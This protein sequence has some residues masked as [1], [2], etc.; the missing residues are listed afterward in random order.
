MAKVLV[1]DDDDMICRFLCTMGERLGHEVVYA[2]TCSEGLKESLSKPFDIVFLDVRLP[3]GDGLDILPQIRET[4]SRPEVII[5]SGIGDPDGAELAIRNGAWDY[6]QKPASRDAVKLPLL[7]A[8]EL[9]THK[10]AQKLTDGQDRGVKALKR[11][12]IIGDSPKM[13]ICMDQ[14]AQAASSRANVVITGETGTGKELF[15]LAVHE[16]STRSSKPFVV[17]DCAALTDS[18]VESTLFGYEKGA[19]TGAEKAQDGMIKQAHGGTLML[20]EI[21]ELPLSVQKSFLRVL[22]EHRFRPVGGRVEVPSDFRLVAATNRN[23][24]QMVEEGRFRKDLFFRIRAQTIDLPP[25]RERLEDIRELAIYHVTKH[26][27]RYERGSKGFSP[28]F[29]DGLIKYD[30]PGN[31]RELVHA[32]ESCLIAAGAEPILF[33]DHLPVHIRVHLARK[34][35]TH[36]P[37]NAER[38]RTDADPDTDLP[39]LQEVRDS[40]L[41]DVERHYLKRLL[42]RTGADIKEACRI[43]GLSRSQLYCL[44]KKHGITRTN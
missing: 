30:W 33:P 34:S 40:A 35:V 20:D 5:I 21:G 16:N 12:G 9:R 23:L 22:Q 36:T 32:M 13:R 37:L 39:K 25:L 44:L 18:L 8:L 24:D 38:P 2:L 27:E 3:D 10:A 1:I 15:A 43:A 6:I 26:C 42:S 17:V 31:V 28:E 4:P 19:F 41:T 29:L 7:R 11:D 14:L